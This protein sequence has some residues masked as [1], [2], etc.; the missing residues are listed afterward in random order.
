M[1][2]HITSVESR[3]LRPCSASRQTGFSLT[4]LLAALAIGALVLGQGLSWMRD[5]VRDS[6]T[7]AVTNVLV[8]HL[9]L[10]RQTAVT[11][12]EPISMCSSSDGSSCSGQS[13]WSAG[14]V[15]FADRNRNLRVDQGDEILRV[16]GP[17][18]DGMMLTAERASFSY[19]PDGSLDDIS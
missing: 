16:Q 9:S 6:R 5:G 1:K 3:Q 14:W 2:R 13:D 18:Q 15:L 4:G 10:A 17:V 19:L 7:S 8:G 12:G 11:R